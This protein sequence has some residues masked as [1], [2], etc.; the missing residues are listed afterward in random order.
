MNVRFDTYGKPMKR[1]LLGGAKLFE[2][3]KAKILKL[4]EKKSKP[5]VGKKYSHMSK[6]TSLK[7]TGSRQGS[8]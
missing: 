1:S 5:M 2:E 6:H 8:V 3:T 4:K 7:L